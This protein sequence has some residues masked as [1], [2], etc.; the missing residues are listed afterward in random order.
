MGPATTVSVHCPLPP[1]VEVRTEGE[2]VSELGMRLARLVLTLQQ[3]DLMNRAPP[4][5]YIT[6]PP[7]TGKTVCLLLIGLRWLLEGND[8][9]VVCSRS[10]TFAVS[11]LIQHQLQTTLSAD[12]TATAASGK[13]V[14]HSHDF[15]SREAEVDAAVNDLSAAASRGHNGLHVL[16]DEAHFSGRYARPSTVYA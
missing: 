6:G 7:G 16:L 12:P 4:L 15:F 1:R 2:A 14:F 10:G 9:H 3:V 8:V 13:V 11:R 5:V